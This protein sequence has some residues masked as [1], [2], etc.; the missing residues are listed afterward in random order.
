LEGATFRGLLSLEMSGT[1]Q[2][3]KV[4]RLGARPNEWGFTWV[5][6]AQI[7]CQETL[8]VGLSGDADNS[9]RARGN[10]VFCC[11][12]GVYKCRARCWR[13]PIPSR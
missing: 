5:G 6:L 10:A 11:F 13:T 3:R 9:C 2:M 1:G 7:S 4:R 8:V 12:C